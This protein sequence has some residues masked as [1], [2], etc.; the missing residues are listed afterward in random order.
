MAYFYSDFFGR[1]LVYPCL[2]CNRNIV[3]AGFIGYHS[4]LLIY[5]SVT[6]AWS[7]I[8]WMCLRI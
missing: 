2:K 6:L 8:Y 5:S 1:V 4:T 7:L 3:L